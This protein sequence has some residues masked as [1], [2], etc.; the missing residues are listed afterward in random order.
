MK[1]TEMN[2]ISSPSSSFFNKFGRAAKI[3]EIAKNIILDS[4]KTLLARNSI[5][6]SVVTIPNPIELSVRR[7]KIPAIIVAS[8]LIT[9]LSSKTTVRNTSLWTNQF[10]NNLTATSI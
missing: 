4:V 3:P 8:T 10:C 2:I 7:I 6:R 5:W 9:S 1:I